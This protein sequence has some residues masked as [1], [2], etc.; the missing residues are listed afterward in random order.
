MSQ[1]SSGSD[2]PLQVGDIDLKAELAQ[3]RVGFLEG[4]LAGAE[5]PGREN[6]ALRTRCR[7][8]DE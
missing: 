4:P 8:A 6:L 5:P 2:L 3:K 7:S 1:P